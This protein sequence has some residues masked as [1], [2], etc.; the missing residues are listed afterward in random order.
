M[1]LSPDRGFTATV[2]DRNRP[3][4]PEGIQR[5][6]RPFQGVAG[7]ISGLA[8]RQSRPHERLD[9]AGRPSTTSRSAPRFSRMPEPNANPAMIDKVTLLGIHRRQDAPGP[10]IVKSA[11][12]RRARFPIRSAF[13]SAACRRS[14]SPRPGRPIP[15]STD[16]S[17][18]SA[19]NRR[20]PAR[21]SMQR[22]SLCP[23]SSTARSCPVKSITTNS[24]PVAASTWSS[25]PGLASLSVHRRCRSRLV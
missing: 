14:P 12:P 3:M 10:A 13:A 1:R 17:S 25:R 21:P 22:G 16:S 6:A 8:P 11:S 15:I 2:I 18:A 9:L 19:A 4:R 24:R 20:P 5:P 7:A 23:P